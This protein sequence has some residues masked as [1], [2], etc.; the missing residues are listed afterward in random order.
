[1]RNGI[2]VAVCLLTL[3]AL[4]QQLE[5][6]RPSPT[7]KVSQMVG[8]TEVVVEYSSPGVNGRQIFGGV[9]PFDKLWRTGANSATRITF[10][11]EVTIGEAKLAAG[12][13][14][15]FT[16]P[17]RESWTL[18]VNKDDKGSTDQYKQ[19]EDVVRLTV[20]PQQVPHRERM[21]FLFADTTQ[22]ETR[23]EL[24]WDATR[25]SLPIH[26]ATEQQVKAAIAGLERNAWRPFN[27]AARYLLESKKDYANALRLADRSLAIGEDWFN[28]WTRAQ[29]L[30]G[31]GRAAEAHDAAVKAQQLGERN[32]QGFF[33][34]EEVGRAAKEWH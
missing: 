3:P 13:Y 27:S 1:M 34:A 28:T 31:L 22:D 19:A 2:V 29:A 18:I 5:L 21:T 6:P 33:L 14:S 30:H 26:A 17:G 10:S 7:A 24:E 20:R 8:L 11:R 23:L 15:I 9:V 16:V 25:V 32:P 12:S 4:A